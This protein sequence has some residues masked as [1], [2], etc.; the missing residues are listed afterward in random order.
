MIDARGRI[1]GS[2]PLGVS[3]RLD[4]KL[5]APLPASVYWKTGDIPAVLLLIVFGIA[6][7]CLNRRYAIDPVGTPM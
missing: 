4:A 1:V 6:A 3:G 7:L 5:P 2:M